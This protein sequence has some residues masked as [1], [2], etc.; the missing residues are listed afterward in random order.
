MSET[1]LKRIAVIAMLVDHA[2]VIFLERAVQPGTGLMLAVS[3][4]FLYRQTGENNS[5]RS[6]LRLQ[7]RSFRFI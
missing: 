1:I 2:A 4:D 6:S 5:E 3:S 7:T